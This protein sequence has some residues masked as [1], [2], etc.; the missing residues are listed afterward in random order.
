MIDQGEKQKATGYD[1]FI[2]WKLF[3]IPLGLLI[4]LTIIPTP[5]SMLDVGVEYVFGPE[6]VRDF[7]SNELFGKPTNEISQWQIQMVRMMEMSVVKS[8]FNHPSFLKRDKRWCEQNKIPST[9]EHIALVMAFAGQMSPER[10]N[11]I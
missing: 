10:F 5:K 3:I 9:K 1:R 2:N 11:E 7:F 8:S 4:L 6:Y